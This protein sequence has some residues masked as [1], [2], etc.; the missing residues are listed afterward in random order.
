[1]HTIKWPRIRQPAEDVISLECFCGF[2]MVKPSIF[3]CQARMLSFTG[4]RLPFASSGWMVLR[5]CDAW[6][7]CYVRFSPT[8]QVLSLPPRC[9]SKQVCTIIT[10]VIF[11]QLNF[12][13]F[14]SSNP[15]QRSQQ[16]CILSRFPTVAFQSVWFSFSTK[17]SKRFPPRFRVKA[18]ARNSKFRFKGSVLPRNYVNSVAR[19]SPGKTFCQKKTPLHKIPFTKL[20]ISKI[21]LQA[22]LIEVMCEW[23]WMQ[24][25]IKVGWATSFWSLRVK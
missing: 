15:K 10:V 9:F 6:M 18:I 8:S 7:R 21:L 4:A 3:F 22:L 19:N 5:R 23:T 16:R 20:G 12:P 2:S 11:L 13:S 25:C 1:M 14:Y 17:R 24:W